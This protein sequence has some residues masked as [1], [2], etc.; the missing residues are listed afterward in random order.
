MKYL[1]INRLKTITKMKGNSWDERNTYSE[2]LWTVV[3]SALQILTHLSPL[4]IH[5]Q[6]LGDH[7]HVLEDHKTLLLLQIK[8]GDIPKVYC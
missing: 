1:G 8:L 6:C 2:S 3:I 4:P 7:E 5:A